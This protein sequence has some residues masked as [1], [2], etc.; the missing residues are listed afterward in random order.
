[1]TFSLIILIIFS[2]YETNENEENAIDKRIGIRLEDKNMWERRAPLS[3]SHVASL[4]NDHGIQTLIQPSAIRV[5]TDT[6]YKKTS[7]IVQDDLSSCPV[8]FGVKEMPEGFFLPDRT[9]VFFSHT[10]KGQD[11]NM[12][13]LKRMMAL[14]CNLIDYEKV[15]DENGR[16]LFF[17]RY[18]G[19]AGMMDTL[20]ALGRRLES[21]GT[22]NPFS[23]LKKTYEYDTLENVKRAV[24]TAGKHIA[25]DGIDPSLQPFVCGFA[26]YGHVS[27]GAQ[28]IYDLLPVI[29]IPPK[30]LNDISTLPGDPAQTVY[31][32]VFKEEHLVEPKAAEDDFILQ[33][34]YDH[35]KKYRSVFEDFLPSMTVFINAIYWTSDYPRLITN[36]SLTRLFQNIPASRLRVIGDITC[37]I[38]GAVECTVKATQ[39]DNPVFVYDPLSNTTTDGYEGSGV[40]VMAVDNL[41]CELPREASADFGDILT[42]FV[43]EIASADFNVEYDRLQL[44][45]PIKDGLILHRGKFT[46]P[47]IYMEN[48][49]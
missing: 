12:S 47:F 33:D 9:Y 36:E 24:S 13:M 21:E 14:G 23:I 43:P 28:E 27:K 4:K 44:S 3:P 35:P 6:E 2:F 31:K 46:T 7:A 11:Y 16:L 32:V 42:R 18:A 15:A 40:V 34:Y 1:M 37:D 30:A 20:W 38:D 45:P 39:P 29:E 41:P 49:I 19:L 5:F 10:I 26:G 22:D 8:V 25:S 48:F 17:G